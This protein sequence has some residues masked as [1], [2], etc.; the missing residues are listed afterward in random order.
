[1]GTVTSTAPLKVK[2]DGWNLDNEW[3]EV[4]DE[5]QEICAFT[6]SIIRGVRLWD[7]IQ[8]RFNRITAVRASQGCGACEVTE[9]GSF[10]EAVLDCIRCWCPS[11]D[12][13][14]LQAKLIR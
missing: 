3:D 14:A 11:A 4:R 7:E 9:S 12:F 10:D 13:E 6:T 2:P 1:M 5:E 8:N